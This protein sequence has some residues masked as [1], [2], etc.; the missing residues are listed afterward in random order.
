MP[1]VFTL[2]P[3][4]RR[5]KKAGAAAAVC[6]TEVVPPP[7]ASEVRPEG[8]VT[9]TVKKK[10]KKKSAAGGTGL[11]DGAACAASSSSVIEPVAVEAAAPKEDGLEG[12]FGALSEKK[13]VR[14]AKRRVRE[15]E[16]AEEAAA[17]AAAAKKAAKEAR[18]LPRDSVFGE[19]YDPNVAFNPMSAP[20]HRVRW[21]GQKWD[22]PMLGAALRPAARRLPWLLSGLGG[23][24]GL[25]V[26]APWARR[27]AGQARPKFARGSIPLPLTLQVD[28]T[29]GYNVY[30]AH[31]L[32]LGR[33]GDTSLCPFDC[34]CCY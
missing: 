7:A 16:E 33:G 17:A 22:V 26:G 10:K 34:K 21:H 4:K 15:E 19:A 18:S 5:K 23:A 2:K 25:S 30:K 8:S 27:E 31:A 11:M 6:S 13:A 1:E 3:A 20:I 14:D 28:Q 32:G 9:K 29:S 12:I 24:P